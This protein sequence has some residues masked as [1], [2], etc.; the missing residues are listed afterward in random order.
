[1]WNVG[2][3]DVVSAASGC[4]TGICMLLAVLCWMAV[5]NSVAEAML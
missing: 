2:N 4:Y 3:V 5:S 1:M